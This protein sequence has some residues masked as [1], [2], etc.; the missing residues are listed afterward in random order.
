MDNS[1]FR[2]S[3]LDRISSPEQ[4]NEYMKVAGS[5][6]WAVLGGLAVTFIAFFIWGVMGSIPETTEVTG[7]AL[8]PEG[9]PLAV[10]CYLQIDE[11]RQLDAGMNVR[12]SPDYAPREQYGYIYGTVKSIGRSPVTAED[13]QNTL[14]GDYRFVFIPAGNVIEVIVEL[15]VKDGALRWSAPAGEAIDVTVGSTCFLTVITSERKPYELMFR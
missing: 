9:G 13:V 11:A 14:G 15:E 1:L 6:V 3:A 2:K 4:L 7:T 10:Y 8:A 5:G 12:V